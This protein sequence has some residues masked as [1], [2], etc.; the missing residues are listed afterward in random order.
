MRVD[1]GEQCSAVLAAELPLER[2]SDG[3]VVILE[4]QQAVFDFS[5]GVEVVGREHLALD[6]G[7]VHLDLVD[8]LPCTG[9]CTGMIVGQRRCK[10]R[11]H[12]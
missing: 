9:V 12:A 1:L 5:Q 2:A 7:E 4:A 3:A 11:V 8:Q 10:R 6:A